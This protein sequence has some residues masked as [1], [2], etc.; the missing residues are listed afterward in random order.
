[1]IFAELIAFIL[2]RSIL[3]PESFGDFCCKVVAIAFVFSF[4]LR[5]L[6]RRQTKESSGD[7]KKKGFGSERIF[8]T[9]GRERGQGQQR[10]LSRRLAE[11]DSFIVLLHRM[12]L[13]SLLARSTTTNLLLHRTTSILSFQVSRVRQKPLLEASPCCLGFNS[14]SRM[15]SDDSDFMPD[16]GKNKAKRKAVADSDDSDFKPDWGDTKKAK[17]KTKKAPA[18]KKEKAV[19]GAA[20]KNGAG[21]NLDDSLFGGS[22]AG[23]DQLAEEAKKS[24]GGKK[25]DKRMSVERIY[26]KKSQLEHILLR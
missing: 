25:K 1:M 13:L 9:E 24:T 14:S 6:R 20:A 10:V 4:F 16:L 19:N 15:S 7:D 22:N 17:T 11:L 26:Q 5:L 3:L 23:M 18:P 12:V 2:P 21:P 8:K